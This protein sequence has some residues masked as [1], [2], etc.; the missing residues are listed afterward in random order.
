MSR[1][2]SQCPAT[3]P[4][5]LEL[6]GDRA[7]QR[8]PAQ[9]R[10]RVVDRVADERV[11]ERGG[12]V[13]GLHQQPAGQQLADGGLAREARDEREIHP[14]AGD[15]RRLRGGTCGVVE[16][17]EPH[18]HRVAHGRGQRHVLL[19]RERQ[20]VGGLCQAAGLL[21]RRGQ[22]L[23]EER[24]AA[25]AVVQ[26]ARQPRVR[27]G[28]RELRDALAGLR[29]VERVQ[30]DLVECAVAPEVV[31]QPTQRVRAVQ[32]VGAVGRHD[33]QRELAQRQ[34]E[35]AEQLDRGLVGPLQVVEQQ[36]RGPLGHERREP[37]ADRLHERRAV[38]ASARL[39]ELGE[40]HGEVAAQRPAVVQAA[41]DGAQVLAERS[42][43]R[44]VGRTGGRGRAA[45]EPRRTVAQR[46]VGE[47]GLADPGLAGHEQQA[48]A[49]GRGFVERG[50]QTRPLELAADQHIA[51]L[52][53]AQ[54]GSERGPV[55]SKTAVTS[56]TRLAGKPPRLACS[57]I[58]SAL[59]ASCTQ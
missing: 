48:A 56:A 26:R 23:D 58:T 22:L 13:R 29:L 11:P 28:A 3:S 51:S 44:A 57:R 20:A 5:S 15:R 9:P 42:D 33:Q 59:S 8:P 37:A 4:A 35:R 12:A 41:R 46:R 27:G 24:V 30:C 52:R 32:L 16:R 6:V 54:T 19:Q 49:A 17:C 25:G 10:H 31:P 7:V 1:A 40:Q 21:Q 55:R 38:A 2:A 47:P 50:S 34:R 53:T 45:D 39:A 43:D 36:R 14:R 18:Q